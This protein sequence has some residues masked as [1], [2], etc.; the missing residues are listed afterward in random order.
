MLLTRSQDHN[1]LCFYVSPI[2]FFML[3]IACV[4]IDHFHDLVKCQQEC[5]KII[6]LLH[7][8]KCKKKYLK[9]IFYVISHNTKR[10]N[11]WSCT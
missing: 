10:F 6:D 8:F 5:S 3:L 1:I 4:K 9:E 7:N 2:I 11:L